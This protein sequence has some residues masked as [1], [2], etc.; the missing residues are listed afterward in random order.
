[1]SI[2]RKLIRSE[3]YQASP[4]APRHT[5]EARYMG[6]DLL[7]FVSGVELAGFFTDAQAAIEGGQRYCDAQEKER[8]KQ[9]EQ[10]RGPAR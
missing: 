10:S 7:S 3:P 6:P 8:V 1:M 9:Q 4:E 2:Q 5:L